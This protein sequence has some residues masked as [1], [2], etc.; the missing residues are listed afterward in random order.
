MLM[1]KPGKGY[2]KSKTTACCNYSLKE[3]G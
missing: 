2:F 1:I 3:T